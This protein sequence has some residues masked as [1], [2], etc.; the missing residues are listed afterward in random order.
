[1][2]LQVH[3]LANGCMGLSMLYHA[4]EGHP[5]GYCRPMPSHRDS[6][7]LDVIQPKDLPAEKVPIQTES[8]SL[9]S[10]DIDGAAPTY[11][12]R[13]VHR[14]GPPDKGPIPGN[15][16][17]THYLERNWPKNLAL[18]TR[19][20]EKATPQ[21]DRFMT[22]RTTNPLTPRYD[23]PS[24]REDLPPAPSARI[25]EGR[26]RDSMEFKGESKPRILERNYVRNPNE[27]G[28]IEGSRS[29]AR[30]RFLSQSCSTPRDNVDKTVERAGQRILSSK[31]PTP[32]TSCPL[33]P[34]YA[35]C[36]RTTH[37]ML[38]GE[39]G[40]AFA[41]QNAGA[42]EKA[43]PRILHRANGEPQASLI[44]VDLPGAAPQRFKGTKPFSIYDPPEVTPF[45][46]GLQLHCKDIEGT[47]TG[48]RT[49]GTRI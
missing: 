28:D 13:K 44:R 37:P 49:P 42:I 41:P 14:D 9:R 35:L 11:P 46:A 3:G 22:S 33:D 47:Q 45:A 17:K 43:A 34:E 39:D 26:A 16:S 10:H 32:R 19:D 21:V 12:H 1:M 5:P 23:L 48:T 7:N 18:S 36:S 40:S 2:S 20:I 30:S 4:E 25:H 6:M 31:C 38:K 15:V 24:H 8:L 29:T 27:S